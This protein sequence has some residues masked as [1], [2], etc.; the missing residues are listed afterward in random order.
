MQKSNQEPTANCHPGFSVVRVTMVSL[1]GKP[2]TPGILLVPWHRV[3]LP[4]MN[5]DSG[6]KIG[7]LVYKKS[8]SSIEGKNCP[9][10]YILSQKNGRSNATSASGSEA[11]SEGLLLH[12]RL[13]RT[14][15]VQLLPETPKRVSLRGS[16]LIA[17]EKQLARKTN[18]PERLQNYSV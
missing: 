14:Q 3:L 18:T 15:L 6:T 13:V 1:L 4:N 16:P 17:F 5:H 8:I 12:Q 7:D 11:G 2:T 10:K 9:E